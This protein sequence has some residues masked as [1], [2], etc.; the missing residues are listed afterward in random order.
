MS[1]LDSAVPRRR[2]GIWVRRRDG[3]LHAGF[4]ESAVQLSESAALLFQAAD[5]G[6]TVEQLASLLVDEYGIGH[7]EA[8][9]D[10][11]EFLEDMERQGLMTIEK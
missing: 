9:Q 11:K 7:Q 3:N 1:S 6:R 2:L 8:L 4:R 10:T 5:G